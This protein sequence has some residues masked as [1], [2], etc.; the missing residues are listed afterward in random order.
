MPNCLCCINPEGPAIVSCAV[1]VAE[2]LLGSAIASST[3][4]LKPLVWR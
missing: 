1:A 2:P 3:F 4:L